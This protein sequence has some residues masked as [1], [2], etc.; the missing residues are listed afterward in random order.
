[1][2]SSIIINGWI[3]WWDQTLESL[4]K[5]AR[6]S[7]S[8]MKHSCITLKFKRDLKLQPKLCIITVRGYDTWP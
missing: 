6:T 1:M 7:N 4:Q 3:N 8:H 2:Q 5:I